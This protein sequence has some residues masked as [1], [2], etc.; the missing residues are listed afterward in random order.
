[1]Q[2]ARD[3]TQAI[4]KIQHY[5]RDGAVINDVTYTRSL[6]LTPD[7]MHLDWPPQ[8]FAE[9]LPTHL[10]MLIALE[11]T[12]VI[13]GT[14]LIHHMLPETWRLPFYTR[15]IGIETMRSTAACQLY[16]VMMS[17]HRQAILGLLIY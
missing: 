6:I 10:E 16:Q 8:N 7:A 13:I 2:I 12:L 5:G 4:F 17:E 1:M 11:P 3:E 9:L 14:G 15:H